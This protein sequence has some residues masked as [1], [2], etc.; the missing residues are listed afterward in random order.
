MF[1]AALPATSVGGLL[2]VLIDTK[3]DAWNLLYNYQRPVPRGAE[4]IGLWWKSLVTP[5]ITLFSGNQS[6]V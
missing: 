3:V 5:Q 1:V 2:A 4:S 6:L